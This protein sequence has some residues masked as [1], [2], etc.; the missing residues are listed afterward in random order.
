MKVLG[1][2]HEGVNQV[3]APFSIVVECFDE[4]LDECL[5]LEQQLASVS[6]GRSEISSSFDS[7]GQP[8]RLGQ[9]NYLSG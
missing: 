1:H 9:S 2:H 8:R 4:E 6:V 3:F 7:G 5:V